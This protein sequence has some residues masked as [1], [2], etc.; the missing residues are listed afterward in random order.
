MTQLRYR[1]LVFFC[2]CFVFYNIERLHEPINIASFVYVFAGAAAALIIGVPQLQQCRPAPLVVWLL[3]LQLVLTVCLGLSLGGVRL[4]LT[5]TELVAT[6]VTVLLAH[7]IGSALQEFQEA[8]MRLTV[9]PRVQSRPFES[10]QED[11]YRELRRSRHYRRPL[12][13]VAMT[14]KK[15]SLRASIPRMIQDAQRDALVHYT[16]ARLGEVLSAELKDCDI[17][18]L[19]RK[20][21]FIVMLPEVGK[22]S[23][24]QSVER[25]KSAGL[26]E[27]GI[28]LDIGAACF[29]DEEVTLV[30]LLERATGPLEAPAVT[31]GPTSGTTADEGSGEERMA[32]DGAHR[33]RAPALAAPALEQELAV[34]VSKGNLS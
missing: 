17:L 31:T 13:V 12:A 4:P 8:V 5:V 27:L 19:D 28:E 7:G 3:G 33:R 23:V 20:G 30:S 32:T 34:A 2:W 1:S 29:P 15:D 6:G 18:T 14:P 9:H 22:E 24:G 25:L 11:M 16:N 10:G 26:E 21:R